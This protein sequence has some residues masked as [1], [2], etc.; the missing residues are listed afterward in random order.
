MDWFSS[1]FHF[2]HNNI[3]KYCNRPF[4]SVESMNSAILTEVNTK[5]KPS[6]TLYY[7][8]DLC[9][10]HNFTQWAKWIEQI[11]CQ[12]IYYLLGNHEPDDLQKIYD[13]GGCPKNIVWLGDYLQPKCSGKRIVLFHYP[14]ESWNG[15]HK[16]VYHLHSHSHKELPTSA[17][18]RRMDVGVDC[19]NMKVLSL[20]EVL[21]ILDARPW[22]D[23]RVEWRTKGDLWKQDHERTPV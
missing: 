7:L 9:M 3:I 16:G 18:M 10:D 1:D 13:D 11:K 22:V 4:D 23:P 6:D 19:H 8:G 17:T 15:S 12:N 5:V 21:K 14:I 2:G 20:D